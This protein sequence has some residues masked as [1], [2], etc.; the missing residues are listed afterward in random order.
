M[1]TRRQSEVEAIADLL[2]RLALEL[3]AVARDGATG[4]Q[5]STDEKKADEL[6]KGMRVRVTRNDQYR[7]R[8]GTLMGRH[9]RQFWDIRLDALD[10][11]VAQVIYKK[12][13]GFAVINDK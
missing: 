5:A 3:R 10:G 12:P 6:T 13:D 11:G 1:R 7:G 2:E 4:T 8:V 9:G